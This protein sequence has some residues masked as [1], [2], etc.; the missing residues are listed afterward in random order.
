MLKVMPQKVANARFGFPHAPLQ[1]KNPDD[2]A[3]AEVMF[4]KVAAAYEAGG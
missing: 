1:D 3:N 2:Q 4:K